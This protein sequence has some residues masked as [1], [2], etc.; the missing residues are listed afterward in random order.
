VGN[1]W[2]DSEVWRLAGAQR[3]LH[4][5]IEQSKKFRQS[6]QCDRL[7]R[8][9]KELERV[10]RRIVNDAKALSESSDANP[11]TTKSLANHVAEYYRKLDDT[12]RDLLNELR[13]AGVQIR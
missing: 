12:E 7:E 11:D 4:I 3:A 1:H 8:Q 6:V 5:A 10:R 2:R 13:R 9:L